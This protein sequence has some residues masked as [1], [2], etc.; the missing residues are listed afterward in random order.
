MGFDDDDDGDDG[1]LSNGL[2]I[3]LYK[4]HTFLYAE[5]DLVNQNNLFL[6]VT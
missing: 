1:V 4:K 3:A 5:F 2:D 6:K